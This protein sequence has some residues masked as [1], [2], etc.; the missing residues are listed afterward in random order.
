M[1][2]EGLITAEKLIEFILAGSGVGLGIL[3]GVSFTLLGIVALILGITA[4]LFWLIIGIGGVFIWVWMFVDCLQRKFAT[5]GQKTLWIVIFILTILIGTPLWL[6][7]FASGIYYFI[8]MKPC[9]QK[10]QTQ[11][12][13]KKKRK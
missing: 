3:G 4:L 6:H 5:T 11:A 12:A 13:K 1:A 9:Q 7:L 8:V 10:Q 2:I